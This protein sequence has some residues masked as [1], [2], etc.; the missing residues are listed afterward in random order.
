VAISVGAALLLLPA[1]EARS[2]C[3]YCDPVL[4]NPLCDCTAPMTDASLG[5][6]TRST[7]SAM[8]TRR[9]IRVARKLQATDVIDVLSDFF[10]LRAFPLTSGSTNGPEFVAQALQEWIAVVG[11]KTVY[12]DEAALGRTATSRASTPGFAMSCSRRD[13]LHFAGGPDRHRELATALQPNQPASIGYKPP[14]PDVFV[15]TF[16]A[17][18]AAYADRACRRRPSDS[19]RH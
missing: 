17:W 6:S 19:T 12:I 5:C 14:E 8:N 1:R 7:S 9:S 3:T 13:L 10:I 4:Q 11:A 15:P 16:V 18:P 2:Q